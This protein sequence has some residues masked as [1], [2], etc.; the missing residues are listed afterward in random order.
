[1]KKIVFT[2]SVVSLVFVLA[3]VSF[4]YG[5]QG[6][7]GNRLYNQHRYYYNGS[8]PG[9]NNPLNLTEE[10][11][12]ELRGI[13]QVFSEERKELVTALRKKQ[14]ELRD[15]VVSGAAAEVLQQLKDDI[16]SLQQQQIDLRISHWD[17]M[18]K[19]L[20]NEQAEQLAEY[21]KERPEP[22]NQPYGIFSGRM[23]MMRD[24]YG[25]TRG[26]NF[27]R[28]GQMGFYSQMGPRR[29]AWRGMGCPW[30]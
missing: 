4:A 21:L 20:T 18:K 16:V 14:T 3:A 17:N 15:L 24:F 27:G 7:G 29:G 13:R 26:G 2:L 12:E 22:G 9:Q 23:F 25:Q 11:I 10:Q 6:F 1:M 28:G 19:V 8:A 30:Y 5:G